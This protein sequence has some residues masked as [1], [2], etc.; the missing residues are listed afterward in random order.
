MQ[1]VALIAFASVALAVPANARAASVFVFDQPSAAPND[2]V[3]VR[4]AGT[5]RVF[6]R[7]KPLQRPVRL[8]LLRTDGEGEIRSRL[9]PRLSFIGSITAD[10]NGRGL[11]TFSVPP[12]DAGEYTL[13][14][15]DGRHSSS[16]GPLRSSGA[17]ARRRCSASAR[18]RRARSRSRTRTGRRASRAASPGTGMAGS[19]RG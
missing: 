16:S 10:R 11:V 5:P 3:V 1:R 7:V 12:L 2:R 19:G 6:K 17:T 8:Y 14:S 4:T 18:Q 13:A 9:D 15:W